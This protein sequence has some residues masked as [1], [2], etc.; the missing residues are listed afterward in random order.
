MCLCINNNNNICLGGGGVSIGTETS[1]SRKFQG[2]YL[3]YFISQSFINYNMFT[4]T[5]D[6]R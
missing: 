4:F 2:G 3:F 1:R 5:I 6:H